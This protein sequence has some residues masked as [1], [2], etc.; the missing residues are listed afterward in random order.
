[1]GMMRKAGSSTCGTRTVCFR[2][3][4]PDCIGERCGGGAA[5][6][7]R[8]W[9]ARTL[10]RWDAEG[11]TRLS[12]EDLAALL[13]ACAACAAAAQETTAGRPQ[14]RSGLHVVHGVID[15]PGLRYKVHS[16]L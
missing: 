16:A 15:S 3:M 10:G 9:D 8:R 2:L 14:R 11:R 5:D 7:L 1:M 4:T 12:H 6:S 13:I